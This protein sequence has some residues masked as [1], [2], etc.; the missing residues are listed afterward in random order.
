VFLANAWII[1]SIGKVPYTW[2]PKEVI[3]MDGI[4]FHKMDY[5]IVLRI[6]TYAI[7]YQKALRFGRLSESSILS[8][9]SRHF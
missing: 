1:K 7:G 5:S 9:R 2:G 4:G 3:N 8:K 6:K